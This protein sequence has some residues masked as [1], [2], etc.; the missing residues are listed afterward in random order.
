MKKLILILLLSSLLF[1]VTAQNRQRIGE[2]AKVILLYTGSILLNA[3]GDGLDDS[4]HKDWGHACNAASIA[5][6]LISPLVLDYQKDKWYIYLLSYTSLRIA[7]FDYTY[8]ATRGIP[9]NQIGSV[10]YWDKGLQRLN[11]PDT[12]M[13]RGVSLIMGIS[14]PINELKH[15]KQRGNKVIIY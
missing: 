13:M 7:L 14:L 3:V 10:S 15:R 8:N 9:I 5:T 11:P 4:G 12:Y 1:S 6:L 2:P